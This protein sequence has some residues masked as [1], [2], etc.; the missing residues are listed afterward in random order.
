MILLANSSFRGAAKAF[1][2]L[3]GLGGALLGAPTA[4]C[5]R[6]WL[7]RLGLYELQRPL[8]HADDWVWI[9]DH[10]VQI[11]SQR[12]L[13][14]VGVQPSELDGHLSPELSDLSVIAIEPVERSNADVI[15]HQLSDAIQRTGVPRLIV[16]DGCRELKKGIAQF[17]QAH[18]AA[19]TVLR[20]QAQGGVDSQEGVGGGWILA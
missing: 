14:I 18:P 15:Q 11:G 16:S 8:P 17:I 19:D 3:L 7:M 12:C 4:N 20:H 5:G 6:L 2:I 1:Q 10:T 9:V 13:V